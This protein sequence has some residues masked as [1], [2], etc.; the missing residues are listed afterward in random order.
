MDEV[1]NVNPEWMY[2]VKE[3]VDWIIKE[4]MYCILNIHYDGKKGFWL[5]KGIS[6]KDRYINL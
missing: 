5:S 4:E 6:V 2:R 1:G 3:V